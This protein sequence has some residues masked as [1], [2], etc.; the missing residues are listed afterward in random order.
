M[1]HAARR[2]QTWAGARLLSTEGVGH[3][4]ILR[5]RTVLREVVQGI[6]EGVPL[7]APDLVR[8]VDHLVDALDGGA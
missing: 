4:R 7:P 8:K 2:S 3:R 5:D 6:R 1:E